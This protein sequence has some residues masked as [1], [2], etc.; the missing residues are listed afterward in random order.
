[1]FKRQLPKN[2]KV[3]KATAGKRLANADR[4]QVLDWLDTTCN[5]V[6]ENMRLFK[7]NSIPEQA[8]ELRDS[9]LALAAVAD[10][11][12]TRLGQHY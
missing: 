3:L 2:Y 12:A 4:G 8:V 11:L 5:I 10:E 1:M 6:L 9:A 7:S